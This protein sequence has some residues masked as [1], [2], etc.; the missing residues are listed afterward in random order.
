MGALCCFGP[1]AANAL[2]FTPIDLVENERRRQTPYSTPN[3]DPLYCSL[4]QYTFLPFSNSQLITLSFATMAKNV[5]FGLLWL[6]LLVFIAWPVAGFCAGI[7]IL[8][9]PFEAV[10]AFVKQITT[11][12]EKLITW[13]REC[14]QGKLNKQPL[15]VASIRSTDPFGLTDSCLSIFLSLLYTAIMNCQQSFPSPM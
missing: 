7:W 1:C 13:P 10:F 14:G 9:Q 6:L 5:I 3:I 4:T 15:S 8:L 2:P 11:F 12:L